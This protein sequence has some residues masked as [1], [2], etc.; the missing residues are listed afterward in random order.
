MD[1][2]RQ[3]PNDRFDETAATTKIAQAAVGRWIRRL[4]GALERLPDPVRLEAAALREERIAVTLLAEMHRIP[5]GSVRVSLPD[6]DGDGTG[7]VVVELDPA[8]TV[9]E[10]AEKR[11]KTVRKDRRASRILP[12]RQRVLEAEL[13]EA[14]A[15]EA[16]LRT[17]PVDRESTRRRRSL[18]ESLEARLLPRGLWP[19]PP[20]IKAEPPERKPVRW[21]L[22][23]GWLLLAGRSGAE[24]DFLTTRI[25]RPDDLWF[26]VA[27]VPGS[28]VVLR[29]PDGRATPAPPQLLER[30][31]SLAAWL[32]KL[33]AQDLVEV[34]YTERKR[35]RKPR[36]A[37]V[38]SVV[39]EQS[40]SILVR[41]AP[42]PT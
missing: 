33:R 37:P 21:T 31:A 5:R 20:R 36:K 10:Q 41:P 25:A 34:R 38:G 15:L 13:A 26:H 14:V 12:E 23:E 3:G 16:L 30:A 39:M 32:S 22:P 2:S 18:L 9:R 8:K 7:Q 27:N 28:H 1:G 42:P 35:V 4:R 6:Y 17:D 40:R 24:N 19:T 11:L 29:S